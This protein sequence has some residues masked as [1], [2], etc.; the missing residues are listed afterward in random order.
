MRTIHIDIQ[1]VAKGS[2]LDE[3]Y[4]V[5]GKATQL[6]KLDRENIL[7]ELLDDAPFSALQICNRCFQCLFRLI[8]IKHKSKGKSW[9]AK[10]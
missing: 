3:L 9:P 5:T 4:F 10:I 7:G 2:L 6:E 1:G 8:L